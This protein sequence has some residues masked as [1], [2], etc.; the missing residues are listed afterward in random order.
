MSAWSRGAAIGPPKCSALLSTSALGK[1]QRGVVTL[2]QRLLWAVPVQAGKVCN[3]RASPNRH[4]SSI[5][6]NGYGAANMQCAGRATAHREPLVDGKIRRPVNV[7][8]REAAARH[9]MAGQSPVW[10]VR[11]I[12]TLARL[13]EFSRAWNALSK[14]LVFD[15]QFSGSYQYTC[16]VGAV[17]ARDFSRVWLAQA[18]VHQRYA[19]A[20]ASTTLSLPEGSA[21]SGPVKVGPYGSVI[22]PEVVLQCV[23]EWYDLRLDDTMLSTTGRIRR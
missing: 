17:G 6:R 20:T 16:S 21:A 23:W 22:I 11:D 13:F 7:C 2:G 15:G 9:A 14:K 18:K 12:C 5:P 10:A 8:F 3:H 19:R 4:L 1:L